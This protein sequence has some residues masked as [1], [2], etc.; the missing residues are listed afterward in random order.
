MHFDYGDQE[1]DECY[2]GYHNL[3]ASLLRAKGWIDGREFQIQRIPSAG[4]TP[5]SWRARLGNALSFAARS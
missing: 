2:E 4:H 1:I 3:L 5:I